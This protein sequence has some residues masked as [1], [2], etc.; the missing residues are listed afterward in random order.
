MRRPAISSVHLLTI[1]AAHTGLDKPGLKVGVVGLGGLG[2]MAVKMAKA[3][4]CHVTVISTSE[5]KRPE[6][7]E[8]L[9]ADAFLVSKNKEDMD[10]VGAIPSRRFR[11]LLHKLLLQCTGCDY[12]GERRSCIWLCMTTRVDSKEL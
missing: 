3:F 4:G 12:G 7:I 6:A 9:G 1:Y 10:K 8:H 5:N 2:H 11:A